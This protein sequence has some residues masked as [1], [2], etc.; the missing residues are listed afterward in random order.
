MLKSH[1]WLQN[2]LGITAIIQYSKAQ[3]AL[4]DSKAML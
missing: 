3:L 2:I 1:L 4:M